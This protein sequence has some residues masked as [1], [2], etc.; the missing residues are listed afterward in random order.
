MAG[1]PN[2]ASPLGL[3]NVPFAIHVGANDGGYN[4]NRVAA[5]W[6]RKLD[7]LRRSDPGG[8]VH[9]A[10]L[11]AGRGHW[12]D[13]QDRKAIA[14]MEQF[15]RVPLPDRIVWFQDD[16][17]HARFYWLAVPTNQPKAGQQIVARRSGQTVTLEG[18]H[19]RT[20]TVLFSDAMVDLDRPVVVRA[21]ETPLFDGRLARTVA[22]LARTLSERGDT[23]LAFSA[24]VTVT[25]P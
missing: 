8:Y 25:L 22:T 17:T 15:T 5:Q 12:M 4:R 2:E 9:V 20:V 10:E 14:W 3:R 18:K 21:P 24:E 19:V 13:L 11:H 7:D 6:A 23:N 1:H 16:V